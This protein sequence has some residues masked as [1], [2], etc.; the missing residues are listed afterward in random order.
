MKI[1]TVAINIGAWANSRVRRVVEHIGCTTQDLMTQ[2][3]RVD[4]PYELCEDIGPTT[5]IRVL[6]DGTEGWLRDLS[7][8]DRAS[9]VV[10]SVNH[11]LR[12]PILWPP[13]A[14]GVSHT[15]TPFATGAKTP[16]GARRAFRDMK[17]EVAE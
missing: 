1:T 4:A 15:A 14:D 17:N 7:T 16:W 13:R 3:S 12:N 9:A 2:A 5:T 8:I 6:Q 10:A 11:I